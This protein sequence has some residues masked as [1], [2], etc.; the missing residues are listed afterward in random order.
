MN[1]QI[2]VDKSPVLIG[3]RLRL[4]RASRGASQ[5]ELAEAAGVPLG[6]IHGWEDG[7]CPMNVLD[8]MVLAEALGCSPESLVAELVRP[9]WGLASGSE[10]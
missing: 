9:G 5:R 3:R 4:W 1:I 7:R 8:A 10:S 2:M 6:S